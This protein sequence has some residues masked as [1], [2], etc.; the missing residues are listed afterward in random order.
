MKIEKFFTSDV[1][2]VVR[3]LEFA[4]FTK[5]TT[6]ENDGATIYENGCKTVI[7]DALTYPAAHIILIHKN[8][9]K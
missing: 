2:D 8:T 6:D 1:T 4:G 7:I 9:E 5:T 3:I